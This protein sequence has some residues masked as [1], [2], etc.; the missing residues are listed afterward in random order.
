M[1]PPRED[2]ATIKKIGWI[3]TNDTWI[4]TRTFVQGESRSQV[5]LDYAE[6]QPKV[7]YMKE[8]AIY[9]SRPYVVPS[10]TIAGW[11][12]H[13]ATVIAASF[14]RCSSVSFR[15][16]RR[17]NTPLRQLG[18]FF[19]NMLRGQDSNLRTLGYEPRMIPLHHP[20][21]R[22]GATIEQLT[23]ASRN[24]SSD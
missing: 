4:P 23:E 1:L 16:M 3:R 15:F 7:H 12:L 2:W 24:V 18:I 11:L 17:S 13:Y 14:N 10:D 20:V 6:P 19:M 21:I 8:F 22:T 9:G 5:Y